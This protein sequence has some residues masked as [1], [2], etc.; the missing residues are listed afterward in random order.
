MNN[1]PFGPRRM[2]ATWWCSTSRTASRSTDRLT[3]YRSRSSGSDP[4]DSPTG[5]PRPMMSVSIRRATCA[6]S[7]PTTGSAAALP[8]PSGGWAGNGTTSATDMGSPGEMWVTQMWAVART[9]RVYPVPDS[10]VLPFL[11]LWSGRRS[12]RAAGAWCQPPSGCSLRREA[13]TGVES[14]AL[15]VEHRVVDDGEGQ[16]GVLGRTPHPLREG[17]VAHQGTGHLVGDRGGRAG[18]E[19][20][21][22]DGQHP[23]AQGAEVA[24]H[25]ERH[26]GDGSL[27]RGVGD[28]TDLALEGGDRRGVDDDA[29]LVVLRLVRR[30][31]RCGEPGDV[32]RRHGVE[33]EHLAEGLQV[34]RAVLAERALGHAAT[35]GGHADVQAAELRHGGGE[36]RLGAGEVGDVDDVEPT[37]H[38]RRDLLAVGAGPVQHGDLRAT[39]GQ[40]LGSRPSHAGRA[41]EDDGL[42]PLDLHGSLRPSGDGSDR[43]GRRGHGVDQPV[44]VDG[45]VALENPVG[46]G[47]AKEEVQVVLPGEADAT[48]QLQRRSGD[49]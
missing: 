27:G 47:P 8:T 5:Q 12:R 36:D 21:G 42:L 43:G 37:T 16:L 13:L 9:M 2:R 44:T 39:S 20:A 22:R 15:S 34:V 33:V 10:R 48:V 32:E 6:A 24:G 17:R 19:E 46:L 3:P 30:H 25:G 11:T 14:E 26:P 4:R 49:L 29:A 41:A 7:F 38:V 18:R 28:L 35:G 1:P 23:D 45:A 31:V 40:Q